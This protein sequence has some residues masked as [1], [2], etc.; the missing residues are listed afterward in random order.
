MGGVIFDQKST[1]LSTLDFTDTIVILQG[2]SNPHAF[3]AM[4]IAE[5]NR[6]IDELKLPDTYVTVVGP[7]NAQQRPVLQIV[8]AACKRFGEITDTLLVSES[9]YPLTKHS[10]FELRI[11]R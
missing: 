10:V 7:A 1:L 3:E 8:S 2:C 6:D 11:L 9:L 4:S 5:K